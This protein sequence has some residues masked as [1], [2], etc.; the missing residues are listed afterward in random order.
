VPDVWQREQL[1]PEWPPV[2]GKKLW[3]KALAAQLEIVLHRVQS[4][5]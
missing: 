3:L 5:E 2:S 4:V 1:N